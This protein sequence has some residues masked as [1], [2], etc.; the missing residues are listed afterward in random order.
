MDFTPDKK[1][2]FQASMIVNYVQFSKTGTVNTSL[3]NNIKVHISYC[4]RYP[5]SNYLN[6]EILCK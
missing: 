2:T 4:P 5:L 6:T 1:K 3:F